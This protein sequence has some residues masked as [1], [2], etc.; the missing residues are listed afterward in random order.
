VD[1]GL[2]HI[3]V[4]VSSSGNVPEVVGPPAVLGDESGEVAEVEQVETDH[5][6]GETHRTLNFVSHFPRG[7]V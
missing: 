1:G 4:G 2:V 5:G 7:V 3:G 6:P